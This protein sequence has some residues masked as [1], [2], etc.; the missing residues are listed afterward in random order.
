MVLKMKLKLPD[1]VASVQDLSSLTDEIKDFLRWFTHEETKK[2]V[3]A[4]KASVQP[5]QSDSASQLL[6]DLNARRTLSAD[7]INELIEELED[8]AKDAPT[9]SFTLAAPAPAGVKINLVNW[10]RNNIS[11]NILVNFHFNSGILGGMVV[12]FGSHIFDWSFRRQI[13]ASKDNFVK[14]LSDVR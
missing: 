2:Q 9:I 8:Y 4:K 13:L 3:G 6:R 7:S 1:T 12:R 10:C 14:A 5:V 11:A